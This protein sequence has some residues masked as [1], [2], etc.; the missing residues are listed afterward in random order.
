MTKF[1]ILKATS[2]AFSQENRL[3]GHEMLRGAVQQ[4]QQ[5]ETSRTFT[6]IVSPV[7]RPD[8]EFTDIQQA[9]NHVHNL[10]GGNVL[11]RKGTYNIS[12]SIL[13]KSDVSLIGESREGC[14]IDASRLSSSYAITVTDP[15]SNG[16]TSIPS[17]TLT[18]GSNVATASSS[19]VEYFFSGIKS[20]DVLIIEGIPFRIREL[21]SATTFLLDEV[22]NGPT[23][24][25][26]KFLI[27]NGI[28]NT[29]VSDLTVKSSAGGIQ[30]ADA[31]NARV[32][33]CYILATANVVSGS[34]GFVTT[35]SSEIYIDNVITKNFTNDGLSFEAH[36]GAVTNCMSSGNSAVGAYVSNINFLNN[37]KRP[38][39]EV[40]N[41]ISMFNGT[42]GIEVGEKVYLHGCVASN[43]TGDGIDVL[44]DANRL[45]DNI[46]D[47]NGD[48]GII[49]SS[50]SSLYN[51]ALGCYVRD[52]T[53]VGV[54]LVTNA[55]NNNVSHCVI[56]GNGT[57]VTDSGT[58][59]VLQDNVST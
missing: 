47:S 35:G 24:A 41:V 51:T 13:M 29:S 31:Y 14:I 44:R 43:N 26:L 34:S 52:N 36:M 58:S 22:Y 48:G 39:V 11:L 30:I 46:A 59:N 4:S 21:T 53:G 16:G 54:E 17:I 15:A 33:N 7:A 56:E 25:G 12:N 45:T 37:S 40:S 42:T 50:T 18:N 55:N 8:S 28:R 57:N 20:G 32:N 19:I 3:R 2:R 5:F 1:D 49:F 10:G 38:S 23:T 9:I 6:T 27:L